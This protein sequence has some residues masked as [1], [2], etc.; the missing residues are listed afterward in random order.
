MASLTC[1]PCS[2]QPA[3]FLPVCKA[4]ATGHR[5]PGIKQPGVPGDPSG[6]ELFLPSYARIH[7]PV[8]WI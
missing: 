5:Q 3:P 7:H 8:G 4:A 1:T 2:C 6:A